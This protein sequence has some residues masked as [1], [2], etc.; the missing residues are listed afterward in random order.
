M[1][2][3]PTDKQKII[4]RRA[5]GVDNSSWFLAAG[6]KL[7]TVFSVLQGTVLTPS[8]DGEQQFILEFKMS[9]MNTAMTVTSTVLT[10]SLSPEKSKLF[11]SFHCIPILV[12]FND[13]MLVEPIPQCRSYA[14][15]V[16]PKS[17]YQAASQS[18]GF[19][20]LIKPHV[21]SNKLLESLQTND[22]YC[23]YQE[24]FVFQ[25]ACLRTQ[26]TVT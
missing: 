12:L 18:R 23:D 14:F 17:H 19:F 13:N 20:S 1:K 8:R 9:H 22:N 2:N 15:V 25:T 4:Q 5:E 24:D 11:S 7:W 10:W 26:L 16:D 21:G 6:G 3:I